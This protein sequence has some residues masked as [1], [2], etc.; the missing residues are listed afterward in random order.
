M[1]KPFYPN[2]G[3]LFAGAML[4]AGGLLLTTKAEAQVDAYTF[5]PSTDTYAP[6]TGGTPV[7]ALLVDDALSGV[8]PLGFSFV[9]DGTAYTQFKASSN[10]WLTFNTA[11]TAN[12]LTNNLAT[13]TAAERPRVAPF[14]D[15]LD[16]R[17]ANAAASFAT[18]GTAPNRVFI[19]EWLNWS[20]LS[21]SAAPF[22]MQV[23]LFEGTNQV[24]YI[25]QNGGGT[26]AGITASVG[27]SGITAAGGCASFLSLNNVSANPVASGTTE[28]TN[29]STLPASGQVYSFVPPV[30]TSCP[31]PR[32][33]SAVVTN[34]TAAVSFSA[35]NPNPGPFTIIYGPTGFNPAT[36]G[37]T[38]TGVTT[39]SSAITGLAPGS[40]QFFVRQECGGALGSSSL[41][42]A[43]NFSVACPSAGGLTV[44]NTTNT[45][46]SLSWAG[47]LPAGA[48]YTIIYG[49]AGFDPATGGTRI[50]GI[51]TNGTTLNNLT[52]DTNYE[53]YVSIICVGGGTGTRTGPVAFATLLTVPDNDEPCGAFALPS[54]SGAVGGTTI[55]AT[56]SQQTGISLPACS[57][58]AAPKDVW[59][60]FTLGANA[61]S[62]TLNLAGTTAGMVRLFTAPDCTSGPFMQVGCAAA[63]TNN[64]GFAAPVTFTGL[65]AGQRYWLA[66]S[67]FGSSDVNGA[68][69]VSATNTVLGTRAAAAAGE[70]A[71]YPNPSNTGEL[72]LRVAGAQGAGSAALVNA[73]GQVVRQV[74]VAAGSSEQR[75]S[76]RGLAAGVYTLRLTV[77]QRASATKVVLQ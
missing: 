64:A 10:G 70:L 67:G 56:T 39:T 51:T 24:R 6:L 46:A 20:R 3:K 26:P 63:T 71:V 36:G 18:T 4:L 44:N 8:F 32:C 34:T 52:P 59:F 62:T 57:P 73:L 15:D 1:G 53:F 25:Y 54:T 33:L 43:G 74:A 40:Y 72:T 5:T 55:G 13:G 42:G 28:T 75:V 19:F 16:G 2:P 50:T 38:I 17:G 31:I 41:S 48:S 58:A 7:P 14:W 27:L 30:P 11:A 60:V 77:G 65:V 12:S 76:T 37:T 49:P 23:Q 9:F 66:V 69:T 45:T 68:F 47:P 61:T 29:I 21:N 22:S 35:S